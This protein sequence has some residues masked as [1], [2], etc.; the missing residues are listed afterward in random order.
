MN[1]EEIKNRILDG[2]NDNV[3]NPVFFTDDQLSDLIDEAAEFIVA[4]THSIHRT[5]HVPIRPGGQYLY[6]PAL[7]PDFMQ[8]TRIFNNSLNVRLSTTSIDNLS[9]FHQRW[10]TVTGNPEFWFTVS[11][12]I[13]GLFPR[14]VEGG[15]ILRIDYLAWPRS[16]NDDSDIPELQ[17]ASH[18]A[19]HL[20]GAYMGELKKWDPQ[21]ARVIWERLAAH[22]VFASGRSAVQKIVHRHFNRTG[23]G[24]RSDYAQR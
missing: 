13:I 3:D 7:A 19:Y 8:A 5:V 9:Q 10:P 4:E 24:A 1:R 12:D 6:L 21:G 14:P 2:I 11:W 20:F 23:P 22:G 17:S 15:G 18:D 16:L